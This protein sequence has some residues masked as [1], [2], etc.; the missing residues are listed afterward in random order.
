MTYQMLKRLLD[1]LISIILIL[2]LSPF[3]LAISLFVKFSSSGPTFY[4]GT[5]TGLRGKPFLIYKF[6]TMVS[7]AEKIGGFSTALNDHRLTGIGRI[8]RKYKVDEIPQLFNVLKGE[9]SL[10]GP[11][12]QVSYYTNLYSTKEKIILSVRPGIT[13]LASLYFSDMDSTLGDSDV[14]K[15]YEKNIEPVKN[16]LRLKYVK[17]IS[18]FL[19]LRILIETFFKV[20]GIAGVTNLRIDP[21]E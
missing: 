8:L 5:R 4:R 13:D 16:K 15:Y 1:V 21:F 19:D 20:I 9:M 2:F 12:P 6:R 10:V 7:N 18:L 14:D 11:R 3:F 17:E